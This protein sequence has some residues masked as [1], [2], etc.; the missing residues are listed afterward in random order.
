MMVFTVYFSEKLQGNNYKVLGQGDSAVHKSISSGSLGPV[1]M[2]C[3]DIHLSTPAL[4]HGDQSGQAAWSVCAE[5][6]DPDTA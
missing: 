6:R 1:Q 5:A 3:G 2:P 4:A